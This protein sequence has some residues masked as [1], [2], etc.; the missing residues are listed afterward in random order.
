LSGFAALVAG[1]ALEFE[2]VSAT[3]STASTTS[4]AAMAAT[5]RTRFSIVVSNPRLDFICDTLARLREAGA[6]QHAPMRA[7]SSPRSR[8]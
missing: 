1:A 7:E 3:P 8:I 2:V 6:D 4:A 5:A